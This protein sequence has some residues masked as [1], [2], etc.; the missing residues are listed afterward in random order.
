MTQVALDV[1]EP[2]PPK[3]QQEDAAD[4]IALNWGFSD[5]FQWWAKEPQSAFHKATRS[6]D[7]GIPCRI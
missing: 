3:E 1:Y 2:A 5:E 7:R 6:Y 4:Q